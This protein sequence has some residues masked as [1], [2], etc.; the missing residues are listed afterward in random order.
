MK[1]LTRACFTTLVVLTAAAGVAA[2]SKGVT[3][4]HRAE[5]VPVAFRRDIGRLLTAMKII[6]Q[7]K[8]S[9]E[10]IIENFK[11]AAPQVPNGVWDEMRRE[12]KVEFT[13]EMIVDTYAPIFARHFTPGDVKA[14]IGFYES[15]V[16]RKLTGE[17]PL[18]QMEA[19]MEGIKRGE[20]IGERLRQKLK[21][22]GY[23]LNIS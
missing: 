7:E 5:T 19:F 14:L 13:D 23:D 16:G 20:K 22:K 21:A 17:M 6:E 4:K 3:N 8:N 12:I 9:L 15:A 10:P 18:I 11:R 2:Q 1:Q